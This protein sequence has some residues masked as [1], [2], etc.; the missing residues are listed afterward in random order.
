MIP[1]V[2]AIVVMA[3]ILTPLLLRDTAR[4]EERARFRA[5]TRPMRLA[6]QGMAAAI[7]T[8]F[9]PSMQRAVA[10]AAD[11]EKTMRKIDQV[12][13]VSAAQLAE[14]AERYANQEDR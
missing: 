11:M 3:A 1:L 8:A 13:N 10:A 5:L 7:G 12:I 9:L 14:E 6:F 2:A 4:A